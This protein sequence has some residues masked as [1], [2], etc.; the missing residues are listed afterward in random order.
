MLPTA[1]GLNE[2]DE[3]APL[4]SS[5]GL[6]FSTD[7]RRWFMTV[8]WNGHLQSPYYINR[9]E[10]NTL[11][12]KNCISRGRNLRFSYIL[13]VQKI[14]IVYTWL[15]VN[16]WVTRGRN[17]A[18]SYQDCWADR[19]FFFLGRTDGGGGGID[20]VCSVVSWSVV[21]VFLCRKGVCCCE[22]KCSATTQIL[23]VFTSL[24]SERIPGSLWGEIARRIY[25]PRPRILCIG[26]ARSA[27]Y[28]RQ[29]WAG[30]HYT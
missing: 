29:L 25:R 2:R 28:S 10:I 13:C 30:L 21:G 15:H 4:S 23:C 22:C 12:I 16:G 7:R 20:F 19:E 6:V 17:V 11:A 24:S 5:L 27:S 18:W 26:V 1:A 3:I 9:T 14:G 8:N